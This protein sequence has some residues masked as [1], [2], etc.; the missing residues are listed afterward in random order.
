MTR[1]DNLIYGSIAFGSVVFLLWIIPAYTPPYP[2]YGVSASLLPNVTVG[3]ILVLSVLAL[4]RNFLPYLLSKPV[5]PA[6]SPSEHSSEANRVN[7]WHLVRFMLPCVLLM[8]AMT[9]IGFIPAGVVF[10]LVIQYLCGQRKPVTMAI[11]ALGTV[12][13]VYGIMRYG[14]GAPMP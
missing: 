8:P 3:F 4:A 2:G 12:F 1:K 10:M 7:L 9:W 11:V 14:L 13:F 6:E 5:I